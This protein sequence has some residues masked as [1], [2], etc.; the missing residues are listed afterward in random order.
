MI[1]RGAGLYGSGTCSRG[2]R[3]PLLPRKRD[4]LSS[5]NQ[6]MERTYSLALLFVRKLP[7]PLL[8]ACSFL[9][10]ASLKSG[11]PRTIL[12]PTTA[13]RTSFESASNAGR[14]RRAPVLDRLVN[15]M[16]TVVTILVYAVAALGILVWDLF[17]KNKLLRDLWK[18]RSLRRGQ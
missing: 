9:L 18:M 14:R 8:R 12:E 13:P 16:S 7:T 10:M 3:I 6:Q 5:A 15:L 17:K 2:R 11:G 1:P 4:I